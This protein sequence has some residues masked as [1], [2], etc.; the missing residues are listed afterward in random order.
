MRD[1]GVKK[2]P[3]CSWIEVNKRV[4]VFVAEE[5][6][7][8]MIKEIHEYLEEMSRKIKRAGYVP[9]VRWALVKDDETVEGEKEVM[10]GHHSEKLAVAFGLISMRE[11][12]PILVVKNLRICGDCHNAIKFISAIAG[13]EITVR[14]AHRFHCFKEGQCS[15]GDYW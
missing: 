6:S 11:G 14:D 2:K 3:G 9:D 10:L 1:R 13:R 15:C 12:E 5:S 4:H 8:P 7:H